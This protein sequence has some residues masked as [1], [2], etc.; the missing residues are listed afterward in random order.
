MKGSRENN[1]TEGLYVM[2]NQPSAHQHRWH[3]ALPYVTE[4][5]KNA[6]VMT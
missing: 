6:V 1:V 3:L 2:M 5:N 4:A